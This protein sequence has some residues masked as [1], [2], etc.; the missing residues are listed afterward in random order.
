MRRLLLTSCLW[1]FGLLLAVAGQVNEQAARKLAQDFMASQ[2]AEVTRGADLTL[3]RAL[4]GIADG[5]NASFYVFNS[6]V[7]FVMISGDDS[8][9]AV[10]GY[11]AG[12]AFDFQKAPESLQ[13]LLGRWQQDHSGSQ[14]QTRGN[15]RAE[16]IPTHSKIATLIQTRWDQNEPYNKYC[17]ANSK[18]DGNCPTGCVATAMAQIMYYHQ[19]PSTY[20]WNK[21]K[22]TYSD[23]D[24]GSAADA[25]AKLMKDCGDAVFMDYDDDGSA[26][27]TI[28][29]SEALRYDFGYAETT[30]F[31]QRENYTA[32][33][34]DALM[35]QELKSK[36]PVIIGAQAASED[37]E[38]GHEFILDGYEAKGGL[39][40]Y[41]VNWGWSGG[42]DEYYLLALLNPY[43]QGTGG[44]A[45]SSGFNYD[46]TAIIGIQP[47]NKQL[48]KVQRLYMPTI[49]IDGGTKTF[50][51]AS[52]SVDFPAFKVASDLFNIV[53][54]EKKRSYDVA[55][56]LYKNGE[57]KKIL[58]DCTSEFD[59][60]TYKGLKIT[61][62]S[63]S[64]GKD[65]SDGTYEI[66][67]LCREAGQSDW[68]GVLCGY[69]KYI[70]LTI[71][72]K[73]MV[74]IEHGPYQYDD[75]D[76]T[77]NSVK[78][79]DVRQQGKPM[80][81]TVNVTD[82]NL[83]NNTPIFLWG[84]EPGTTDYVLLTGCGTNL[85]AGD[86]GDVVMEYTPDYVGTYQMA[87]SS[88]A[89]EC[90]KLKTFTVDV[91]EMSQADVVLSVDIK[92]NNA[93]KQSKGTYEVSGT[94]LSGEIKVT[95]GGTEPYQDYLAIWLLQQ[96]GSSTQ[97]SSV[98]YVTP[99]ISVGVGK[100]TTVPFEFSDLT[101]DTYYALYIQAH[102]RGEWIAISLDNEGYLPN[103]HIFLIKGGSGTGI[104][105]VTLSDPD[106]DVYN[107]QGVKVGN[108][109][110]MERLPRGVYIVNK[111]KVLKK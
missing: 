49:Y 111:K 20:D 3:T 43:S 101:A 110:D 16:S 83:L 100:S 76:F 17:P 28:M 58:S 102:E 34:W 2:F 82:K 61:S 78:V 7:G 87:I 79:G 93:K 21:M 68:T 19:W 81:I 55:F 50:N 8:T 67:A 74:A 44:N 105:A 11:G 85:D 40:Y 39:G 38:G 30:D 37:G 103:E 62:A 89:S 108:A 84:I 51:R 25:V 18:G 29:P 22:K 71:K 91:A 1:L 72:G 69:D 23:S 65:L 94:T 107:L 4:T 32:K 75:A 46:V 56:A 14:L 47:G 99:M 33:Q 13:Y 24:T 109:S 31:V 42:G 66:R 52:T 27:M 26:A 104:E 88:S 12:A 59:F 96:Q 97:F 36:R 41:H 6:K 48:T 15:T 77:I 45:G 73:N 53:P 86:T 60:S 70:E 57:R 98:D 54:P 106:A 95:N 90:V 9:P 63:L 35:Y 5:D 80:T 64:I 92:A 10:L